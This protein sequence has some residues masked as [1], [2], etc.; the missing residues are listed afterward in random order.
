MI[1]DA[2]DADLPLGVAGDGLLSRTGVSAVTAVTGIHTGT[3]RV[4]AWQAG[5]PPD[6]DEAWGGRE[7]GDD[8]EP[9][10]PRHRPRAHVRAAGRARRHRHGRPGA[11]P[12]AGARPAPAPGGAGVRP[13]AAR[14]VRRRPVAGGP[15]TG[16]ATLRAD[17]LAQPRDCSLGR[18]RPPMACP[19]PRAVAGP[20][21][22][23]RRDPRS[24]PGARPDPREHVISARHAGSN[25][26]RPVSD[27]S[28]LVRARFLA[29]PGFRGD[30][31]RRSLPG[32]A[33]SCTLARGEHLTTTA[34]GP[35]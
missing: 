1:G 22:R 6:P 12:D 5:H 9:G 29:Q 17:A 21:V 8:L 27:R 19:T 30:V 2:E 28:A 11:P 31:H 35:A 26:R 14:G 4:R 32:P 3:V 20:P 18:N 34:A 25:R 10:R 24:R 15:Y 7:R 33:I 16:I 13:A 23:N